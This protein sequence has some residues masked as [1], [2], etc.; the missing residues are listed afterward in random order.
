MIDEAPV[1]SIDLVLDFDSESMQAE[2]ADDVGPDTLRAP[3]LS[4]EIARWAEEIGLGG[5][6]ERQGQER[7]TL[8][9]I[10]AAAAYGV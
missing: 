1:S 2:T 8:P 3:E 6:N 4:E 7:P 10:G 9:S 5:D